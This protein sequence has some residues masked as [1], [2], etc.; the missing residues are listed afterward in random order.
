[1]VEACPFQGALDLLGRKHILGILWVLS[2]RRPRRF[3]EMREAL[4]LS[5]ASLSQRLGELEREGIVTS[6][7]YAEA[8]P[9]VDY[10]LTPAGVELLAVLTLLKGWSGR[11]RAPLALRR[12]KAAR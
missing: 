10:D 4:G 11:H 6:T 5:P 1:M 3:N 9:R 12:A 2:E 7:R 8:P